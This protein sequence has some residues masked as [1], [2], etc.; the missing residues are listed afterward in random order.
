MSETTHDVPDV[1]VV[2]D[3]RLKMTYGLLSDIQKILPD[4]EQAIVYITSDAY[5]RD[6]IIRRC[7][8]P[9]KACITHEDQ[10][11]KAEEVDLT[12]TET[13]TV[14]DWAAGHVLSFF[15]RSAQGLRQHAM[16]LK[17]LEVPS[18]RPPVGSSD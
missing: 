4:P 12:T 2:G 10:L 11:I 15:I 1:L 17:K 9:S 3:L 14:L 5:V 18:A 6:Y 7:L 16:E 8:T 13:S